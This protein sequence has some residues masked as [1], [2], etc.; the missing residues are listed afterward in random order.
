LLRTVSDQFYLVAE[1]QCVP[2]DGDLDDYAAWAAS[3]PK[4]A[5]KD[6][7][8]IKATQRESEEDRKQRKRLEAEQRQRIAPLK[9]ELA[10]L[11]KQLSKLQQQLADIEIKLLAPELYDVDNKNKLRECLDIQTRL[12]RDISD[13]ETR[14]LEVTEQLEAAK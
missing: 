3:H 10:K 9:T 14:W 12:K 1:G 7:P 6:E 5:A 13:V 11:D 2:F 8:K 4:E